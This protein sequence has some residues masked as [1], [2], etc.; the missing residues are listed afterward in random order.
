MNYSRRKTQRTHKATYW[1]LQKRWKSG[2][3]PECKIRKIM[4]SQNTIYNAEQKAIIKAIRTTRKSNKKRVILT[5]SLST[6]MA[7]EGNRDTK[8]PENPNNEK[9]VRRKR[10]IS[11]LSMGTRPQVHHR[12][13]N[14]CLATV[15]FT[16]LCH[17]IV[18]YRDYLH[19]TPR[20]LQYVNVSKHSNLT[21]PFHL[22]YYFPLNI[23]TGK[24]ANTGK[25]LIS[26]KTKDNKS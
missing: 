13:W 21:N 11:I 1:R 17:P 18:P 22:I 26:T 2:L 7:I 3:R 5:D 25:Q 15:V 19:Y 23:P 16:T 6:L 12:K 8:K 14:G 4:R 24:L 10:G 9:N 20:T